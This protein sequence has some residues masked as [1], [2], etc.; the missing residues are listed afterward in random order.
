M[1]KDDTLF[2]VFT[3]ISMGLGYTATDIYL[4]ALPTLQHYFLTSVSHAQYT[5]TSYLLGLAIAQ[6]TS[7]P[8]IDHFGYRQILLGSIV[9]F[10][11]VTLLCLFAPTI[12]MLIFAR[13]FQA[14]FAGIIGITTRASM[15]RRF[16]AEKTSYI[17]MTLSPLLV[18][19]GVIAPIIG[20][21]IVYYLNWQSVFIFLLFYS[22]A[23]LLG[24]FRYFHIEEIKSQTSSL[25]FQSILK[26]YI[27][28]LQ[29]KTFLQCLIINAIYLGIIFPYVLEAPFIYH[30]RG[31]SSDE[32]GLTFIPIA[33]AFLIA[34]QL[35]RFLYKYFSMKQFVLLAFT[36]I[37]IGFSLMSLPAFL[38]LNLAPMII[39]ITIAVFGMGFSSPVAFGKAM[40]IFRENSGSASSLL[41]AISFTFSTLLTL[42]V[43]R[44]CGNN[45]AILSLFLSSIAVS[46]VLFY[47]ILDFSNKEIKYIQT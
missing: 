9:S 4:P 3:L 26:N 11:F 46:C 18:L 41:T 36:L 7:G 33:M 5:L 43:H 34:S 23:I 24:I 40:T 22:C 38:P 32:I 39:G 27:K 15:I 19:S 30:S 13:G 10:I 16:N 35:T 8:I 21:Y 17:F 1:K 45:I 20:G 29:H 44:I 37:I 6:F 42:I 2:I 12:D 47:F 28:I 14:L 31:Y 25:Q